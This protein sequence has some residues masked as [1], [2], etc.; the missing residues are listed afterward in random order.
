MGVDN[1]DAI[2]PLNDPPLSSVRPDARRVGFRG[3]EILHSLMNGETTSARVEY[4]NP[5][6]LVQRLSTQVSTVEDRSFL[7]S[8]A[9]SGAL[10]FQQTSTMYDRETACIQPAPG[11]LRQMR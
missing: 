1:D 7:G 5:T 6:H 3:A 4:V 2:C 11:S 10:L 9:S 8:V